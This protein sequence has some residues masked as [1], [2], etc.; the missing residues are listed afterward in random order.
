MNGI[1][2]LLDTNFLLD[3]LKSSPEVIERL[4]A[5]PLSTE[6]CAFSAITRMELLGFP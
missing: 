2:F 4:K 5:K 6:Q 1:D 3:L